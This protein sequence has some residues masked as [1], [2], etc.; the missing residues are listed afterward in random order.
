M[1]LVDTHCHL[2]RQEFDADRGEVIARAS[3]AGV[4]ALL[5][6]ATDFASNQTVVELASRFAQVYAAVGVHPHD[7]AQLTP[8]ALAELA[9][10]AAREKVV[11]IGEI[12]LDYYRDLSP[13]EIQKEVLGR[14][15]RLAHE[16]GKPVILHCRGSDGAGAE[17]YEDLFAILT[18]NLK[19]PIRGLL[20]CFGGTLEQAQRALDL[21]LYLSFAGNLT[22]A[23]A[24]ALRETARK[25][26]FDKVL[27]E[28]DAPFLAPQAY[29]GK[30]NEPKFLTELVSL[31][32]KLRDLTPEDVARVTSA[33]A[34]SLFGIGEAPAPRIAYPIRRS[35]YLNVTNACTDRCVFC[36]LSLDE[37]WEGQ[38]PAAWVKGHNLRIKRDPTADEVLRAAGDVSGFDEVVFCGYGEPILKLDLLLEAARQLKAKGARRIRL[39]T[40]GHGN[41]IHRRPVAS[42]LAAVV[43]EVSVSLN[44]PD[45]EQYL[46]VCRPVFGLATYEA[47]K[48]FI[49]ECKTAGM[50]VVAT[51]VAMPGIDVQACRRVAEEELKVAFRV[52][53]YDDIG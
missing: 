48:T 8:S 38:G 52:R 42:D 11:A 9:P 50:K 10:L 39:N 51:V 35:L 3:E 53:G 47:I 22:F 37:F 14:L 15:L 28:T 13:R 40:N 32:A 19:A 31:W 1:T 21:G 41:L 30:R 5:D 46:K 29:R 17:A 27:L 7:A 20:H 43:D 6:P 33:N 49:R 4:S 45:A 12:G 2:H 44:T 36:S 18:E 25:V 26:P 23:K 34:W 24:D 16:M